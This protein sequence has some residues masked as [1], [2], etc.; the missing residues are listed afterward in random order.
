MFEK[1]KLALAKTK[2]KTRIGK[3]YYYGTKAEAQA[4]TKKLKKLAQSTA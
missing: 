4:F 2:F 1:L 3:M